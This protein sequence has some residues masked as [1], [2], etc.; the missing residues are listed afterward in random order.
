MWGLDHQE[1]SCASD[2]AQTQSPMHCFHYTMDCDCTHPAY[3]L[4]GFDNTK[5]RLLAAAYLEL[6]VVKA[7]LLPPPSSVTELGPMTKMEEERHLAD[8]G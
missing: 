7:E 3:G 1:L 4:S 2:P 8:K 6:R 5:L